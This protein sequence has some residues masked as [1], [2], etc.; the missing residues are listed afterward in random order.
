MKKGI[1]K[2]LMLLN[3]EFTRVLILTCLVFLSFLNTSCKRNNTAQLVRVQ[4]EN[5]LDF[6][7]TEVVEVRGKLLEDL[8]KNTKPEFLRIQ[9]E[10][11]S[12]L[13]RTQ[14]IDE[15][16]DGNPELWLFQAQAPAK[17]ISFYT[18]LK[19]SVTPEPVSDVRAYSRFVP[20]RT[21]D[22]TWEND[23]VAFRTYGP[24]G[25]QEALAGVAGS[26]LSSGIDLWLKRTE[27]SVI[28]KWYKEHLKNPGYYH[29]DH[30]EG[31]DPYHVG[32]SRGTGGSAILQNDSLYVSENYVEYTTLA[33]GPLRTIFELKYTP[34][35]PFSM[36]ERKRISLDLG[37][38]FSKF[39][40]NLESE[41][42]IRGYSIGITL[43]NNQGDYNLNADQGWVS[44][45]EKIDDAYVG[46]A[47]IMQPDVI[48]TTFA[49]ISDVPDQSNLL[50]VTN[51]QETLSYYA[52]FVWSKSTDVESLEDWG[53][54]I[55][56]KRRS[57]ASPL[58]LSLSK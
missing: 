31:Y 11:D 48:D 20:E 7:R 4:V 33:D 28:D 19:D 25:Q 22:Y 18:I 32:R 53:K 5:D 39:E 23:K 2:T 34:W 52:G 51:S 10:K 6:E 3:S 54:T 58:K 43:H 15:D 36:S 50:I 57:I 8:L 24:T 29:I 45:W 44:H 55:K 16:H 26:T 42:S 56:D 40:I 12:S 35:S 47:V 30:G 1:N 46:E 9:N 41:D 13:L 14:W 49:K 38:Y 37:S 17:G 21:D 27:R